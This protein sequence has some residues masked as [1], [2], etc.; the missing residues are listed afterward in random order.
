MPLHLTKVAVGCRTIE[1]LEKRV[2]ARTHNG[3]MR[4]P[5][6]LRPKRMDE[7]VGGCIHW[8]VKHRLVGRQVIL[9]FEDRKDGRIDIVVAGDLE[10]IPAVPKRAHQGWRYLSD[11]DAPGEDGDDSGT[12]ALPP[13][14]YGKLA[15]MGL[16]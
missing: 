11:D 14:L 12:S 16:V 13:R 15:A 3:E 9:R 6:K 7:L 10:L 8:I 5:T 2:A 4:V 1:A